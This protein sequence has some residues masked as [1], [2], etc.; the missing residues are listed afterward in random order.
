MAC[1]LGGVN[2]AEQ[3]G[4]LHQPCQPTRG[5]PLP[6]GLPDPPH[7]AKGL[8]RPSPPRHDTGHAPVVSPRETKERRRDIPQ[9]DSLW[10]P[11]ESRQRLGSQTPALLSGL[12][13]QQL[14]RDSQCPGG[15]QLTA[16]RWP[17]YWDI[18]TVPQAAG[19]PGPAADP[20]WAAVSLS[21]NEGFLKLSSNLR[22]HDPKF[23][24]QG[25]MCEGLQGLLEVETP[26]P[27]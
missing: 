23:S 9:G 20:L 2:V 18:C 27:E 15:G 4:F 5:L 21:D 3:A 8:P 6:T 10:G 24:G 13:D 17:S 16:G 22:F 14:P 25:A 26:N 12:C 7:P 1:S 19:R 11:A